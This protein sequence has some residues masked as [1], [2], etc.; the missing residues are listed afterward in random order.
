M[1]EKKYENYYTLEYYK[2]GCG[3]DYN[4]NKYWKSFFASMAESIIKDFQPKTVLD[5]GCAYGYLVEALRSRGVEAYGIDISKYAISSADES[6]KPYLKN[7]SALDNLPDEFPKHFDLVVS[8]EMIEHLYEED[9]IKVIEKMVS[10]AD[11]VLLSSTDSDFDEPS[12]FNVQPRSY[13][14]EKFAEKG[15]F[16]ELKGDYT[17]ISPNT[18]LFIKNERAPFAQVSDYE[19]MLADMKSKIDNLE[20]NETE[21]KRE[22][23][24]FRLKIIEIQEAIFN[25]EKY[26]DGQHHKNALLH[27]EI[28]SMV[29]SKSWKITKPIRIIT[30][31]LH[32]FKKKFVKPKMQAVETFEEDIKYSIVVPVYN[33]DEKILH[34][35]IK[36]VLNQTYKNIELCLFDASDNG[37]DYYNKVIKN[38][39]NDTR[40]IYKKSD[41]NY[42][43]AENTNHAVNMATGEYI[44]LLDHDDILLPD[45]VSSTH[46]AVKKME[47]DVYYSDEDKLNM[48]NKH[49]LPFYKPDWSPDLMTSQMYTCHFFIFKKSLFEKVG[50]MRKEYDGAQDYDL[51]L[52]FALETNRICHIPKVI[53]S[54]R[55]VPTSTSINPDSKPYAHEA[56]RKAVDYYLKQKY[57][58]IAY[59][60][61]GRY[62]FTYNARFKTLENNPKVSIII[63]M[64]DKWELTDVCVK[65]IIEK[66]TYSNYEILILDNR[67]EQA[68]TFKWFEEISDYDGR[69]RII[70]ADFEFNWSKLNNFGIQHSSGSVYIFLNNDMKVI[71]NDWIER[72]AENALRD[73]VG[74]VGALLSYEDDT[75]QHAGVVIGYNGYADHVFKGMNKVHF[76]SPFV[77]PMVSRNVSA[78]TGACMAISKKTIEKIGFF[79]ERFIICGSDVEICLR[80][81]KLGLYNIYNAYVELYHYESKSRS[82]YIPE[83]DFTLSTYC[84]KDFNHGMD[85]FYNINLSLSSTTPTPNKSNKVGIVEYYQNNMAQYRLTEKYV[86]NRVRT[87]EISQSVSECRAIKYQID[88]SFGEN[89][90]INILL[91][92]INVKDVFGGLY[93]AIKFFK[94]FG[95][96]DNI[97]LRIIVTDAKISEYIHDAVEEFIGDDKRYS[98]ESVVDREN[99]IL[100]VSKNDIFIATAWWTAVIIEDIIKWQNNFYQTNHPLIYMIQDYEPGFYPWSS[101]YVCAENSY[102]LDVNTIAVF[103]TSLLHSFF[104]KN[105]YKF[106]KE[107]VFE[108]TLNIGLKEQLLK[109]KNSLHRKNRIIIY[110]RPSVKRNGFEMIVEGL[111]EWTKI[112]ENS[113][114]WEIISLGEYFDPIPLENGCRITTLGKVSIEEYAEL[115]LTSKVGISLMFSP[116]PSYPP[117]EMAVFGMKVI[118][119]KFESKDLSSVS[120]NIIS[121]DKCS[122]ETIANM[123]DYIVQTYQEYSIADEKCKYLEDKNELDKI[124]EYIY[125][126]ILK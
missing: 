42:G 62:L 44:G 125:D 113:N 6:I 88:K 78:V 55:E 29:N 38:Y 2:T 61:E 43:I 118:T 13:W 119:N 92:S 5:M 54:W 98:I 124:S 32:N 50:G 15:Y 52:R 49:E 68:D 26:I 57:G 66:S 126:D 85:P 109:Y 64:K 9:C 41:T 75:I 115:M 35:T 51:M 110:G 1:S 122:P 84:Y 80:A 48:E 72:L 89:T 73:D 94:S 63:P 39:S 10:Y 74:V 111:K 76:G 106:Y 36:S 3:R 7:M 79:D 99:E 71:S 60:E 25:L 120:K 86:K 18:Y 108:A 69:I 93:T 30:S 82:S 24:N 114:T 100:M 95:K 97:Y 16:R 107:Y 91:P 33:T 31:K 4:D 101:H 14:C 37:F 27:A 21:L 22:Q 46:Y 8:I 116:H 83:I 90:R 28:D 105:G 56:G 53:Y 87:W 67:S 23:N 40:L 103:N 17:Y 65:S 77:S 20:V 81:Y 59:A 19:T 12:H 11:K 112:N 45:A 117:M 121:L 47:A 102:K 34:E 58:E 104:Q 123:L 96:R 70:K